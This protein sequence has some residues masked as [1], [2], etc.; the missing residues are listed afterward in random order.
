MPRVRY[1]EKGTPPEEVAKL[2]VTGYQHWADADELMADADFGAAS[3]LLALDLSTWD[4]G[5]P[6]DL[7]TTSEH[8][9][10]TPVEGAPDLRR[11]S[12]DTLE[13][14]HHSYESGDGVVVS[15]T[16]EAVGGHVDKSSLRM[17]IRYE[18]EAI[19]A[20]R[21][22]ARSLE[23]QVKWAK[24]REATWEPAENL[25]GATEVINAYYETKPR[26]K[27]K[28]KQKDEDA[29]DAEAAAVAESAE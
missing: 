12:A 23:Y 13:G 2:P 17:E 26:A 18:V 4:G 25:N 11:L 7:P 10:V 27:P 6:L 21:G 20:H 15:L 8:P 3:Y 1:A 19:L 28:K 9:P 29:E 24:W 5:A 16:A 14:G 22:S